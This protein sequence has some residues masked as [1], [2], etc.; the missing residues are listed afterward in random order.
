MTT[1]LKQEVM[2]FEQYKTQFA[3]LREHDISTPEQL[4]AYQTDAENGSQS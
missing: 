3:F 2:R 4:A 1:H